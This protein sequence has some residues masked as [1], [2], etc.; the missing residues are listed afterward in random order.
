MDDKFQNKYRI[1]SNRLQGFDYGSHGSYFVTICSKDRIDYFGKIVETHYDASGND[2]VEMHNC[3]SL[4]ATEIGKIAFDFWQEIP[5][6]YPFVELDEFVIMPNHVHG[7]LFF[8]RPDKTDWNANKFGSQSGNLGAVIRGYKSSVKRYANKNE[9]NFDWQT[10][11]HD[12]IIRD[13]AELQAIRQYIKNNPQKWADDK[14]N[15]RRDGLQS[16]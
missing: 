14:L 5:A 16:V 2:D 1:P 10:R 4:R 11:Y 8:N 13:N 7:I 3:A 6:H 12:N 15:N 9:I